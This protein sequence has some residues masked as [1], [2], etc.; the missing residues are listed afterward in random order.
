MKKLLI[1][2]VALA[3]VSTAQAQMLPAMD[4]ELGY[5]VSV[6][7]ANSIQ[8]LRYVKDNGLS[9]QLDIN[10]FGGFIPNGFPG[11]PNE[12]GALYVGFEH[13]V[14]ESLMEGI[15]YEMATGL[16]YDGQGKISE[17]SFSGGDLSFKHSLKYALP[18]EQIDTKLEASYLFSS[19]LEQNGFY[20]GLSSRWS[21]FK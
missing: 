4:L 14:L 3:S 2:I 20:I 15:S 11:G 13:T 6:D 16:L 21:L 18:I 8:S 1:A 12:F 7:G 9:V 5:S 10:T 17:T 19:Y